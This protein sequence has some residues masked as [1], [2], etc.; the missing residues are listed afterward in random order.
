MLLWAFA[1]SVARPV[2]A[3]N[4]SAPA[5]QFVNSLAVWPASGAANEVCCGV[6]DGV[7]VLAAYSAADCATSLL[8]AHAHTHSH[9][10]MHMHTCGL[11]GVAVRG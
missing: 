3:S 7:I 8:G 5:R 4:V 1:A 10:R 9:L 6:V 2:F 11:Y